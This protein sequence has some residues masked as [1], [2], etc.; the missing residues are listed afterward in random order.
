MHLPYS[1]F[2]S[3][4]QIFVYEDH[5]DSALVALVGGDHKIT[6]DTLRGAA[7]CA[8]F[9]RTSAEADTLPCCGTRRIFMQPDCIAR[10][11]LLLNTV[12]SACK[13]RHDLVFTC[14]HDNLFWSVNN[15]GNAVGIAVHIIKFAV[16]GDRIRGT[17][18]RVTS[19]SP[20]ITCTQFL[21]F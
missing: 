2:E 12:Y 11:R 10:R 7:P 15:A 16:L 17:E 20:H 4:S 5:F 3:I 19:K 9:R 13:I 1:C 14:H 21:A 18:I 6:A 8:E